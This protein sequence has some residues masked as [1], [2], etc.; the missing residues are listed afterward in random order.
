MK[1]LKVAVCLALV[2]IA[3]ALIGQSTTSPLEKP[4]NKKYLEHLIK[5]GID[6]VREAHGLLPLAND[7]ILYRAASHHAEYLQSTNDFSHVERVEGYET[8]QDRANAYGAKNYLLYE[9]IAMI[10]YNVPVKDKDGSKKTYRTYGELANAFV[11]GWV[12]SPGHYQNMI[13]PPLN[14]T[15]VSIEFDSGS[16]KVYAVQKFADVLY[17]YHFEEDKA[18]FTYSQFVPAPLVSNF[19]YPEQKNSNY[20]HKLKNP[21]ME[22]AEYLKLQ[23][24]INQIAGHKE[25]KVDGRTIWVKMYLNASTLLNFLEDAD[26]GLAIEII[27]YT[28]FDCNNP[29]YYTLDS[30]RNKASELSDTILVPVYRKK[31][32]KGFKPRR[33]STW[34]RIRRELKKKDDERNVLTKVIDGIRMPY[35][36]D[37]FK[38]QLGKIPKGLKNYNEINLVYIKGK[39]II[40]VNHFSSVCGEF[41]N[42]FHPLFP[43]RVKSKFVYQPIATVKE[44]DFDFHFKKGKS[45]YSY[46]DLK[47]VLDSLT[48]DAFIVLNAKVNA[49]SSVEGSE[50]VNLKLQKERAQSI[51][52]AFQDKQTL[53]IQPEISAEINWELFK[54]QIDSTEELSHLRGLSKLEL[55][56]SLKQDVFVRR[57]EKYLAKQRVAKV[58]IKTQY[59]LNDSTLADFLWDEYKRL[60]GK[61]ER[62][63]RDKDTLFTYV[64]DTL[65]AM[66]EFTFQK[67]LQK[68][69]PVSLL[70]DF[71]HTAVAGSTNLYVNRYFYYEYFNIPANKRGIQLEDLRDYST[72]NY[73]HSLG[74]YNYLIRAI[75]DWDGKSKFDGQEIDLTSSI[76]ANIGRKNPELDSAVKKLKINFYF[77]AA[78]YFFMKD[79]WV[80]KNEYLTRIYAAYY[81]SPDLAE[82]HALR[83]A[84][85]FIELKNSALASNILKPFAH[86]SNKEIL[87]LIAKLNYVN[88]IEYQSE[89]YPNQLIALYEKLDPADWCGMFVGN[90]NISFQILD[91][92]NFRNFYC[93]KCSEFKNYAQSPEKW[94]TE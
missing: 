39:Q 32:M 4:I 81:N 2:L 45:T 15:G 69:L 67:I 52:K 38:A 86:S 28:P 59:D 12:N 50:E 82:D 65:V 92:E 49:F 72:E 37:Q 93:E 83:L 90:C 60:I 27:E 51:I 84:K 14:I 22:P 75:R 47:P 58:K 13:T 91:S 17:Q 42:E 66:Q 24:M 6:S 1:L 35:T 21:N 79:E 76:I 5:I 41:Y 11:I 9:N 64:L 68:K 8:P 7:V 80:E 18:F 63:E 56:D 23:K 62:Y 20:P 25:I 36:P 87:I 30:R 26:D 73:F 85:F 57:L 94:P 16:T 29:E 78:N 70:H 19:A 88:P 71:I 55:Q 77:K 89:D 44:Y 46:Q 74:A 33:P 61:L 48:D 54:T 43:E 31:L 53:P 34:S 3:T 40:R 10:P